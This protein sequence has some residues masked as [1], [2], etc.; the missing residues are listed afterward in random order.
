ML[1]FMFVLL[2]CSNFAINVLGLDD[3]ILKDQVVDEGQFEFGM[4]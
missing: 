3:T 4:V 1:Q 2:F